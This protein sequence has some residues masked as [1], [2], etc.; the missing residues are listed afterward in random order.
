MRATKP[1]RKHGAA[2]ARTVQMV[3]LNLR[4]STTT[5]LPRDVLPHQGK[6]V[7]SHVPSWSSFSRSGIPR[8]SPLVSAKAWPLCICFSYR[9]S[10]LLH[11]IHLFLWLAFCLGQTCICSF[12]ED[13]LSSQL[14]PRIVSSVPEQWAGGVPCLLY[15]NNPSGEDVLNSPSAVTGGNTALLW[16]ECFKAEVTHLCL[17]VL[18]DHQNT[19][20]DHS[21][22]CS[23][24][25]K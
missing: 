5:R 9:S 24:F 25:G 13:F 15:Q 7:W 14:K 2:A 8:A 11:G 3:G 16:H 12:P 18:V 17:C 23:L 19:E 10:H 1:G 4:L 20:V 22:Y 6:E 21:T